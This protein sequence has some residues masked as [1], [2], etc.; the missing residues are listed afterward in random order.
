M[1]IVTTFVFVTSSVTTTAATSRG[2]HPCR[3]CNVTV[4]SAYRNTPLSTDT[5]ADLPEYPSR[6]RARIVAAAVVPR[7]SISTRTGTGTGSISRVAAAATTP[8]AVAVVI[9]II[10][11]SVV[12]VVV[13][14]RRTVD[15]G[16]RFAPPTAKPFPQT[17][18]AASTC[19]DT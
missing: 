3:R 2:G 9:I 16:R 8:A 11:P 17:A 5:V 15:T 19:A 14:R 12:V 10:G 6:M 1:V 13:G 7:K 18:T 4:L